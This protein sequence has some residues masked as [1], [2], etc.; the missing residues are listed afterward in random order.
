MG[1]LLKRLCFYLLHPD[2]FEEINVFLYSTDAYSVNMQILLVS[3]PFP[4]GTRLW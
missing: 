3:L 1:Y 2:S 4:I